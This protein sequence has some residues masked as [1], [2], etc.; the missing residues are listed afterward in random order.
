MA[1]MVTSDRRASWHEVAG[2]REELRTLADTCG[3]T[4]VRLGRDG[5][6]IVHAPHPG[7]R[8]VGR[9]AAEAAG[10]VGTY[11]H[12]VTDD[13]PAAETHAPAL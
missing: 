10:I 2:R 4:R 13:V 7:Y 8:A 1:E 3:L 5:T 12:V 6:V 9:F 11:V